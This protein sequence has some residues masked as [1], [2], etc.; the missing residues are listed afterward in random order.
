M[1]MKNDQYAAE[2]QKR[3]GN[4]VAYAECVQKN[5]SAA[6]VEGLNAVFADF[7]QCMT[8]QDA[9]DSAAAQALVKKLQGYITAHFYTCT[10]TVLAGLGELYVADE[11]FKSSIDRHAE[12]T[13]T[14][15]S[16][17]IKAYCG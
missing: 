8:A 9:P 5:P 16:K 11:R 6:D 14:F 4:T 7:A 2:V 12:G 10:D 13:A 15:V 17:A 1:E 3:W